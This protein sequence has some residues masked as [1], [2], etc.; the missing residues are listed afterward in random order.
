[1]KQAEQIANVVIVDKKQNNH[2][3]AYHCETKCGHCH[4]RS[5]T[6]T[7]LLI[8]VEHAEQ[9]QNNAHKSFHANVTLNHSHPLTTCYYLIFYITRAS[10]RESE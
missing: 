1:M 6:I 5:K 10:E 3:I 2:T 7:P 9:S 8:F 4:R